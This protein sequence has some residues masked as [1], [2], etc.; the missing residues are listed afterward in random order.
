MAQRAYRQRKE[1][2][3]TA[4]KKRVTTLETVIQ[5][6]NQAFLDYQNL[7]LASNIHHWSPELA[8]RLQSTAEK[9]EELAKEG[10]HQS[11]LEFE[12]NEPLESPDPVPGQ[13]DVRPDAGMQMWGYETTFDPSSWNP[14]MDQPY[15]FQQPQQAQPQQPPPPPQPE[16]PQRSPFNPEEFPRMF[17]CQFPQPTIPADVI[18]L[19]Y[20]AYNLVPPTTHAYTE[21]S[22]TRRLMRM[23]IERA[24]RILSDPTATP[25]LV[26]D[27]F[28]LTFTWGNKA[29]AKECLLQL[30]FEDTSN[31][32]EVSVA[33]RYHLGRA[34]L[35]YPRHGIDASSP[36]P[37]WV[38]MDGA[39]R[40]FL[41]FGRP[42][43]CKYANWA[44]DDMI[45]DLG[46]EGEWFDANDVEEYLRTK[47]MNFDAISSVV[48]GP[49]SA[50]R[51]QSTGNGAQHRPASN[52]ARLHAA[53]MDVSGQ[54]FQTWTGHNDHVRVGEQIE[55]ISRHH[56]VYADGPLSTTTP[57][58]SNHT[59]P[60]FDHNCAFPMPMYS[61][62]KF[63]QVD[64]FLEGETLFCMLRK[65][66]C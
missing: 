12:E 33:P 22:F 44:F 43:N 16:Q 58:M 51:S 50:D 29:A 15:P 41:D 59:L 36:T 13:R 6:M 45:R 8:S 20:P 28:R 3:I 38:G 24:I 49:D 54:S 30:A 23:A 55:R 4:L 37:E 34:G 66:I 56:L 32:L 31:G 61:P 53:L 10:T 62:K 25:D 21:T 18:K 11:E 9:F 19:P 2:T 64:K 42:D 48:E 52:V 47:G 40:P 63:M 60:P 7:A 5:G 1:T 65:T 39:A 57:P 17:H 46:M 26:A 27:H 35:H 14:Q